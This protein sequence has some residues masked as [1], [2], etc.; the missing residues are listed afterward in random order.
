M[1]TIEPVLEDA[2]RQAVHVDRVIRPAEGF[3]SEDLSLLL[4]GTVVE[5]EDAELLVQ[6]RLPQQ[7]LILLDLPL[8]GAVRLV[9]CRVERDPG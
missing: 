3:G 5:V 7:I 9:H 8:I 2:E 6:G 4:K 1:R